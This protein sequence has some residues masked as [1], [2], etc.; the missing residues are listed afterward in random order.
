MELSWRLR[1]KVSPDVLDETDE[2]RD[3][4][5]ATGAIR[6]KVPEVGDEDE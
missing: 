5:D 3:E 6:G 2:G 1:L 4:L